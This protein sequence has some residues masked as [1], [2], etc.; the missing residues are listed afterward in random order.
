VKF[1]PLT[2][3]RV[4]PNRQRREFNPESQL[5]L[6][7]SIC[8]RGLQNPIVVRQGNAPDDWILVSGERRL[9]TVRD[10]IYLVGRRFQHGG[11]PVP[12]GYIPCTTLGELDPLSA[13]EAE[14]DENI[15]RD[16]L[17]WQEESEATARIADLRRRQ[18]EAAGRPAPNVA[19]IA[20]EVFQSKRDG[21]ADGASGHG[22]AE[23]RKRLIVARHLDNAEVAKAKTLDD[24]FRVLQRKDQLERAKRL[25]AQIGPAALAASHRVLNVDC[26][27]W[28]EVA[29]EAQFDVI[30]TDPPYGMGADA[31]GDAGGAGGAVGEHGYDD[32]PKAFRALMEQFAPLSFHV[33][34]PSAALYLFC[35]ID[36][37]G[38]LKQLFADAGWEVHRTPLIFHK[39]S[40]SRW[41]W[42][43]G[44]PQRK[45]E[46]ILYARKGK[47]AVNGA[48][49]DVLTH[50]PDANLGHPAQKPVSLF[51]DLLARSVQPGNSV[52]DPFA[53][54]GPLLPAAHSLGC[55][56]T[57][58]ENLPDAYGIAVARLNE[59]SKEL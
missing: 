25:A 51:R 32:S 53:G 29:E 26:I 37:F 44:G 36:H 5:A 48:D 49:G 14:L 47:R 46:L 50:S 54:S 56:A 2:Q 33:T 8:E 20:A 31:F 13:E 30:C 24:A 18:A 35:D 21:F 52:L 19:E 12:V 59:L 55:S 38:E 45:Y 43:H 40:G 15:H 11:A 57:L 34:K 39:P 7:D 42:P 4:L 41:P 3:I 17:T 28:L 27:S 23:T 10:F 1:L 9:R 6:A 16:D 22:V 58:L